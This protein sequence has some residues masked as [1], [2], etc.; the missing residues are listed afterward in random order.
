MRVNAAVRR[1]HI[2]C[3]QVNSEM[4]TGWQDYWG[5]AHKTGTTDVVVSTLL[6]IHNINASVNMYVQFVQCFIFFV[7][8]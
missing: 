2:T 4:Y 3:T 7:S 5:G 1:Y 6:A 8:L